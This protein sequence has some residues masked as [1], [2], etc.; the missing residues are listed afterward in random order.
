MPNYSWFD[1]TPG[2]QI[3]YRPR[4]GLPERF[5]AHRRDASDSLGQESQ[6]P[7]GLDTGVV[8]EVRRS[9]KVQLFLR[10]SQ[11]KAEL[12]AVRS[13][14]ERER[15]ALLDALSES[16]S[17][18][19]DLRAQRDALENRLKKEN[20]FS[21]QLRG[22]FGEGDSDDHADRLD[23]LIRSRAFWQ[24]RAQKT[25]EELDRTRAALERSDSVASEVIDR[26]GTLADENATLT[27][28]ISSLARQ[29]NETQCL[30]AEVRAASSPAKLSMTGDD[31]DD[32]I[33]PQHQ[34][35]SS[36]PSVTAT[37]ASKVTNNPSGRS[38]LPEPKSR[39]ALPLRSALPAAGTPP[40]KLPEAPRR[41][42]TSSSSATGIDGDS[43]PLMHVRPSFSPSSQTS[44]GSGRG[45]ASTRGSPA[46]SSGYGRAVPSLKLANGIDGTLS[47]P[48]SR[49]PSVATSS[50]PR[51]TVSP[52]SSAG[53]RGR[54]R[55]PTL[56]GIPR[57]R[58]A[59]TASHSRTASNSTTGHSASPASTEYAFPEEHLP[60]R[61]DQGWNDSGSVGDFNLALNQADESFLMQ[62][63]SS[64]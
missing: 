13:Q 34:E 25:N 35:T 52:P 24:E 6:F 16:R 59:S 31:E 49:S 63:E 60:P 56:S 53:S 3:T 62:L 44:G 51:P 45:S 33:T 42:V 17:V 27:A 36:A 12:D 37:P 20:S 15:E 11:A 28:R 48:S 1:D 54:G 18:V 64:D 10:Y 22:V 55:I 2:R 32:T 19:Y 9:D 46:A 5:T 47:S 14:S 61:V 38:S 30:L 7:S 8:S 39:T 40:S 41:R 50:S 57:V 4:P 21:K 26:N 58:V 23:E 29:F 43:S